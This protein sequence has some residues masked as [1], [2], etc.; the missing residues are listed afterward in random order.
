MV[1]FV[2]YW[3]MICDDLP[4]LSFILKIPVFSEVY[5]I[6]FIYPAEHMVQRFFFAKNVNGF[7]PRGNIGN[8]YGGW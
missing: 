3:R 2:L 8:K 6:S 1:H 4:K 7:Q 5:L